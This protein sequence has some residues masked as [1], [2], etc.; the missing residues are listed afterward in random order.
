MASLV[1]STKHLRRINTNTSQT[2]SKNRRGET[3]TN[4]FYEPSIT[5]TKTRQECHK[6]RKLQA[7]SLINR[8]SKILNNIYYKT[9]SNNILKGS[10]IMIMLDLFQACKNGL[11]STNQSM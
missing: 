9:E 8:G 1:N 4:L 2:L 6:K 11:I 7:I 5:L 3:I 10:Y